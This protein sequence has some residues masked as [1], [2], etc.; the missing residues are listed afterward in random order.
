MSR[1]LRLLRRLRLTFALDLLA[2]HPWEL[3]QHR[4]QEVTTLFSLSR[5][6]WSTWEREGRANF[7]DFWEEGDWASRINSLHHHQSLLPPASHGA[8]VGPCA[9]LC[10]VSLFE[11][12]LDCLPHGDKGVAASPW[13]GVPRGAGFPGFCPSDAPNRGSGGKNVIF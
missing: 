1:I 11:K 5:A 4:Y 13:R 7:M 9:L 8:K 3:Q 2:C 10:E 6:L 12:T